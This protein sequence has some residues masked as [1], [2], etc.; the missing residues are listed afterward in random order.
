[1]LAGSTLVGVG[2]ATYFKGMDIYGQLK[3][4]LSNYL[5]ENNI[6]SLTE[7]IGATHRA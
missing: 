4:D 7:L 1:M 2:T 5:Q 3:K 6:N